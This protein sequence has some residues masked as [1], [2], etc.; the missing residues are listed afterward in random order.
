MYNPVSTYRLQFHKNFTFGEARQQVDYFH[1][2]GTGTIYASPVFKAIPGSS[3]GYD[4]TDPHD[5]NP[6]TGTSEELKKL[7]KSLKNRR[8]GWL[9]DIIPNHMAF[10]HHNPWLKDVLEKGRESEFANVFDIDRL[11]RQF[12]SK[13][14]VPFLGDTLARVIEK[15][16]LQLSWK[17]G[18]F[19]LTYFENMWPVRFESFLWLMDQ[20]QQII[21]GPLQLIFDR[22]RP[23]DA[24]PDYSF[25]NGEWE[26]FKEEL[27]KLSETNQ[28]VNTFFENLAGETS[29][30]TDAL[31]ALADNQ[32]YL[33]TYWKETEKHINYRRFFTVNDLI[34][35]RM[36]DEEVFSLYHR[37]LRRWLQAQIPD[38][39]RV[40]HVDGLRY[41]GKYLG[42]LRSLAGNK[43]YITVEKILEKDEQLPDTWPVQGTT[44]YDFL[45]MVNRLLT[46]DKGLS[47]L[48]E[49]YHQMTGHYKE[50]DDV[51]YQSK[52]LILSERMQGEWDNL[53]NLFFQLRLL[54]GDTTDHFTW[55]EIKNAIGEILLIMPVYRLYADHLPMSGHNA[56]IL[57]KV[58]LEALRRNAGIE[59]VVAVF[60]DLFLAE[61]RSG[62]DRDARILQFF[63]RMMQLSGP[64]MAKGLEDTAMYRYTP[65]I[66]RNE[67]GDNPGSDG[68]DIE[69]FHRL[70]Q[71][72]QASRP[73]T[74]N[75]TSTHDTKR[76][77]D[78][79]ARLQI[80]SEISEEWKEHV[81][82]WMKMNRP[83]KTRVKGKEAPSVSEEYLLY[84]TLTGAAPFDGNIDQDFIE[85]VSHFM[86]KALREA[87]EN[88]AW[89]NPS[90]QWE[91]AVRSFIQDIFN[92][93]HSFTPSFLAFQQKAAHYGI[94]N[95]L[96]QLALKCTSPGVPDIYRGTELWD[97]ALVDPDNRQ[98]VDFQYL[99]R[100]LKNLKEHYTLSAGKLFQNLNNNPENGHIKLWM[101]HRLLRHRKQNP[102]LFAKGTYIPL[103]VRGIHKKHI[104]AFARHYK[105]TWHVTIIPVFIS[106]FEKHGK[107][108]APHD[109]E[110]KNT[111]VTLPDEAPSEWVNIFT[112]RPCSMEGEIAISEVM[113]SAPVGLLHA[114]TGKKTRTA[115]LLMHASSLPGR[116]AS[117]DF[118]P[119]AWRFVD[120]LKES[121]HSYWQVLPLTPTTAKYGWSPYSPPSAFAGNTIFISPRRLA[122]ESL[123]SKKEMRNTECALSE[124]ADFKKALEI[125]QELTRSAYENFIT[126]C[127]APARQKFY[128]FC[129]KEKYWLDD[130]AL[131]VLFKEQFDGKP[132]NEWPDEIRD[133]DPEA[134]KKAAK[135]ND[136]KIDL[137][138][139]R[140]YLF[141]GQWQELKRYA[142]HHG[143][144]IIGD[145]PI[146]VSYDNADVWAHPHLF[147]LNADKTRRVVAG[148]P[149]DYFSETGQLWGMPIYDWKKMEKE[150]FRWWLQRLHKNLELYDKVRIDHFRGFES[151]WEV[152]AGEETAE[153]G[154]WQKGPGKTFL[155]RV[156]K[157]FP[158]MPFIA[159]DL[160]DIDEE[161]YHLR[162]AF[163]LPGMR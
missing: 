39:L 67:V 43:C 82:E 32:H 110:W 86:E 36:E 19:H 2:L 98:P 56:D 104:L 78:A 35:L 149:P 18:T 11:H 64:L 6:E 24:T 97:L 105:N 21:P 92:P 23:D 126:H 68:T 157:E 69:E 9:Q 12:R 114:D 128:N 159:E 131:F 132:W 27:H 25:L 63:S 17:E 155:K 50:F 37:E 30:S 90:D 134:L 28:E 74:M 137:T 115:G 42:Q 141:A 163:D 144:R 118:G 124:K 81:S 8:I 113:E 31:H 101:T 125:R 71:Q 151:Y 34:C 87:K 47:Q 61:K 72:R 79:R 4:V 150:D 76:G 20:T 139:Y 29:K 106:Q 102:D 46:R 52:K 100:T 49:F 153:N 10:S 117:G 41:P 38:G 58:L 66:G 84:Q 55:N 145:V 16:E 161:V 22:F 140:Q 73:L 108:V 3:H 156:Q 60:E 121:G 158:N 120:F 83:M 138:K 112:G 135:E 147:K 75:T 70:M 54:E 15:G 122:E 5:I 129:E 51:V 26:R 65:F 109:I 111:R 148:V 14:M 62:G 96:S 45:G 142:N 44:G 162:D 13:L 154:S 107:R 40:D 1:L 123:I 93:S 77:E 85:R 136:K 59:P 127:S 48:R 99:H 119:G 7:S 95:S 146:Y 130:Y 143:I 89:N 116:F 91:K 88:T 57:K 80:L 152:P 94:F 103:K 53:T 33:L 133:R 160:G